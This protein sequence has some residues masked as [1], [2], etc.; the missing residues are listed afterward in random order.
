MIAQPLAD[1]VP[2]DLLQMS[3]RW[4]HFFAGVVWIGHL[5]FFNWVNAQLAP[6]LDAE[7]KKKV[8]PELMPRALFWFRWGAAFTWLTGV[9]L[10]MLVYYKHD[11]GNLLDVQPPR[12]NTMADWLPAFGLLIVGFLVYDTM[13]KFLKTPMLKN[14]GTAVWGFL[15]IGYGCL[16]ESQW[17]FSHRA[18]FIHIAALFGTAM[19]ANV[20]MRIWPAQRRIITAVKNGQKPVDADVAVAGLRSRHNT[21]MSVPLLWLMVS[22]HQTAFT[23]RN[24]T[25]QYSIA[26]LFLIGFLATH[27][28]Y[29]LSAKVQGF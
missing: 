25:W 17:H 26:A 20:W 14:I 23:D 4:V 28:L 29:K 1:A 21:Y 10:A 11:S 18:I 8:V 13:F 6:K 24:L 2:G 16:L 15:A 9:S 27:L 19:A 3:F 12:D 22:V 7:T 5:Y